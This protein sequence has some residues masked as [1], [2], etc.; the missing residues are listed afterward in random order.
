MFNASILARTFSAFSDDREASKLVADLLS[1]ALS[2]CNST[3]PQTVD[4]AMLSIGG[5]Q[6]SMSSE[7]P[8]SM[9]DSMF[10]ALNGDES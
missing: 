9:D 6:T 3:E 7:A 2:E 1:G 8:L 4:P 5:S 10:P